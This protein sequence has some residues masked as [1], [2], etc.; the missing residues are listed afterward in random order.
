MLPIIDSELGNEN[1]ASGILKYVLFF[2]FRVNWRG[3]FLTKYHETREISRVSFRC[4]RHSIC[5]F[6]LHL[7]VR[8]REAQ[9]FLCASHI[10]VKLGFTLVV[11]LHDHG[12]EA[13]FNCELT[14]FRKKNLIF[15]LQIRIVIWQQSNEQITGLND[16]TRHPPRPG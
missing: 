15:Y 9:P 12:R 1:T 2:I 4:Q 11:E 7:A 10:N 13:F 3:R 5:P 6:K 8:D 16:K 14:F